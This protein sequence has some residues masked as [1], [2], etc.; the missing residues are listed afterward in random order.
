MGAAL[1]KQKVKKMK[2]YIV[3]SLVFRFLIHFE[4][5]F[6]Y[7]IRKYSNFIFL[8]VQFFFNVFFLERKMLGETLF[9]LF[10]GTNLKKTWSC[11]GNCNCTLNYCQVLVYRKCELWLN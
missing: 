4:F 10:I 2:K 5:I 3:S 8:H 7:G 9:Q 6:V 1:K 11:L